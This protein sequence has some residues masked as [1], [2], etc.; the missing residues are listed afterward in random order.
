MRSAWQP[1]ERG[2]HVI[3][4]AAAHCLATGQTAGI[5]LG[6]HGGR[7]CYGV[8]G[9]QRAHL[10]ARSPGELSLDVN[11]SALF[12]PAGPSR[13]VHRPGIGLARSRCCVA[14]VDGGWSDLCASNERRKGNQRKSSQ[15]WSILTAET[16]SCRNL[17]GGLVSSFSE[18]L[19]LSTRGELGSWSTS[20]V[21]C[22]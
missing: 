16:T 12:L 1:W 2:R 7:P 21:S 11:G 4:P 17:K 20:Q 9:Q 15:F 22:Q 14:P 5:S 10:D 18:S 19:G 13:R 3:L 8:T 6:E